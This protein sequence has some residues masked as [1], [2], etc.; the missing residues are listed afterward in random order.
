MGKIE[1][2]LVSLFAGQQTT[3]QLSA[4]SSGG[5]LS[6]ELHG[7]FV[8]SEISFIGRPGKRGL[9]PQFL[10]SDDRVECESGQARCFDRRG[11]GAGISIFRIETFPIT[12][13]DIELEFITVS[14]ESSYNRWLCLGGKRKSNHAL[15][16]TCRIF[17]LIDRSTSRQV[18]VNVRF[19]VP[20]MYNA[21][22]VCT[23]H[24]QVEPT[25]LLNR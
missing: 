19:C 4:R 10:V 2:E 13:L 5:S 8:H 16:S 1:S 6:L 7:K 20:I 21:Q 22:Q 14:S 23:R 25:S 12:P 9:N 15:D 3:A 11:R 17:G 24:R 18:T